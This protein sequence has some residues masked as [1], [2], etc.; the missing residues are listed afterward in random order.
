MALCVDSIGEFHRVVDE[1]VHEPY[2]N[3]KY[4]GINPAVS[5]ADSRA[6]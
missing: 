6:P 4:G 1:E 5:C 3:M 2:V